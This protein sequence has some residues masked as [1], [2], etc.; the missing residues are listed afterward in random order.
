IVQLYGGLDVRLT[1][2]PREAW[3]SALVWYTGSRAHMGRL[4]ALARARGWQL[5][6]MGL[7]D[8]ATGKLLE[9]E[10]EPAVYERLGLPLIPPELREDD[11]EIEAAQA[12][13]LPVLVELSDIKG[14]L[15][16]HTNW[17]DGTQTL[18]E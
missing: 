3:G 8:D 18:D 1:I 5:T 11:G 15:H 6:A 10:R 7:E 4:E 9:R 16:T 12:G 2:V 13:S 14:D 17:T